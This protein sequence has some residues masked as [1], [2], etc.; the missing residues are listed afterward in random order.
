MLWP[1]RWVEAH[2]RSGYPWPHGDTAP[3]LQRRIFSIKP[4]PRSGRRLLR[5][6][7]DQNEEAEREGV[8]ESVKPLPDFRQSFSIRESACLGEGISVHL[9]S[10]CLVL[11]DETGS[12]FIAREVHVFGI[13]ASVQNVSSTACIKR[14]PFLRIVSNKNEVSFRNYLDIPRSFWKR[15]SRDQLPGTI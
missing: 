3:C 7:G 5:Q 15:L 11:T 13:G 8:S 1:P 12:D 14:L 6:M 2:Q 9:Y 10:K 4:L